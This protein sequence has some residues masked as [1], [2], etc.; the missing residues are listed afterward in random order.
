MSHP[1]FLTAR[2]SVLA[3]CWPTLASQI[4]KLVLCIPLQ[5]LQL[6]CCRLC[7]SAGTGNQLSAASFCRLL[8]ICRHTLSAPKVQVFLKKSVC[9]L[10]HINT[11]WR[12]FFILDIYFF[13]SVEAAS[14]SSRGASG[15][16]NRWA[17]ERN[18]P[19]K[20][21]HYLLYFTFREK[22]LFELLFVLNTS[23]VECRRCQCTWQC[24]P[25]H[26]TQSHTW[27]DSRSDTRSSCNF[28]CKD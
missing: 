17:S 23:G 20:R 26:Y 18:S 12:F 28:L 10:F 27:S 16:S 13:R 3:T 11:N 2:L 6:E 5:V 9:L 15:R 4:S 22:S 25:A 21:S 19:E 1:P 24:R 14:F 7:S 8:K